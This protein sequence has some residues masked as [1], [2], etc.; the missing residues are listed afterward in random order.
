VPKETRIYELMEKYDNN[1]QVKVKIG[2]GQL[3]FGDSQDNVDKFSGIYGASIRRGADRIPDTIMQDTLSQFGEGLSEEEKQQILDLYAEHG[4]SESSVTEVRGDQGL[5]LTYEA[6]RLVAVMIG[7]GHAEANIDGQ[8]IFLMNGR[9]MLALAE[10][11]N[12]EPGRYRS[13]QAAFD[14]IALSLDGFSFVDKQG[15]VQLMAETD[16]RFEGRTL[17]IREKPY[18]PAEE[19]D[20]FVVHSIF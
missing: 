12:K 1:W 11:L 20:Q 2:L 18:M 13:T 3:R 17:E 4:P 9:D 6:D 14:N 7:R 5:I 8:Q 16:E 10:S 19:M 15:A